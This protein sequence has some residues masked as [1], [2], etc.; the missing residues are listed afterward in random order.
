MGGERGRQEQNKFPTIGYAFF[1]SE[2]L[3]DFTWN[4]ICCDEFLHPMA[5]Y[6]VQNMQH[7]KQMAW[8]DCQKN[9]LGHL[10]YYLKAKEWMSKCAVIFGY[11]TAFRKISFWRH[12]YSITVT[13]IKTDTYLRVIE[14][15]DYLKLWAWKEEWK[16]PVGKR[17]GFFFQDAYHSKEQHRKI[18]LIMTF[19]WPL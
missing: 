9:L 4:W 8:E 5:H 6:V 16:I 14:Q 10:W 1:K 12:A 7:M 19:P 2:W 15:K 3:L 17:A 11:N 18:N 13:H